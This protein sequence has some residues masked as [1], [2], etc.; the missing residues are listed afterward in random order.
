MIHF[1]EECHDDLFKN[2]HTCGRKIDFLRLFFHGESF[3]LLKEQTLI[4]YEKK[5]SKLVFS[6][7]S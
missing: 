3:N 1:K 4:Y 5:S 2:Q 6:T 7:F